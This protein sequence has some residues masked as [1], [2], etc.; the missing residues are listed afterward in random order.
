MNTP[1]YE[2][3]LQKLQADDIEGAISMWTS[4][5][6]VDGKCTRQYHKQSSAPLYC[7][8]ML[9][10]SL[11]G[12]SMGGDNAESKMYHAEAQKLEQWIAD[13]P[14]TGNQPGSSSDQTE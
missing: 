3:L 5:C 10:A 11:L 14:D 8:N 6:E 12:K 2:G 7:A 13:H 1:P 9:H 4:Y